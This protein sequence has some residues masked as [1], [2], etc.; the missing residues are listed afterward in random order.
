M[1]FG[2]TVMAVAAAAAGEAA[3]HGGGGLP[4]LHA[5]DFAPQLVWLV[6]T[7][8]LLYFI[9]S[10]VALPRIGEVIE[11]RRDR[12]Q[13]D[14]DAAENAK[15][16]T[17]QALAEYEQALADARSN[18]SSIA[19]D[20]R[21]KLAGETDVERARVD[22]QI[23]AKMSEAE[24]RISEMKSKALASVND[25]AADTASAVVDKLIGQSVDA[26]EVRKALSAGARE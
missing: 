22:E 21:E 12:I 17:E 1:L 5:P 9:M 3:E 24:A 11:E 2:T 23:A 7:F 19:K 15:E 6:I 14:L 26:D 18:A 13:R 20:T 4:Q 10:K 25:I 16:Q 8:A